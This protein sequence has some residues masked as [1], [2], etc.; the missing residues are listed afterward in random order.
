MKKK[1][2]GLL[3][4]TLIATSV[5]TGVGLLDANAIRRIPDKQCAGDDQYF[6]TFSN[7]GNTCWADNGSIDVMLYRVSSVSSGNNNGYFW[8]NGN[9]VRIYSWSH[10]NVG[11]KNITKIQILGR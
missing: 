4:G 11:G 9:S 3:A 5:L 7:T 10:K 6:W 1:I 8:A 2:A